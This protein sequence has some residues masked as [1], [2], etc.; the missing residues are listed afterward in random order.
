MID[1]HC[2]LDDEQFAADR[3]QKLAGQPPRAW[4]Q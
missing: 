3:T 2:H 4:K 1:T